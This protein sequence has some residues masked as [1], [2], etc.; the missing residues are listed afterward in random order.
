MTGE[1][2]IGDLNLLINIG[3]T[4]ILSDQTRDCARIVDKSCFSFDRKF[5]KNSFILNAKRYFSF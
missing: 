2:P 1:L 5:S 3:L 4:I